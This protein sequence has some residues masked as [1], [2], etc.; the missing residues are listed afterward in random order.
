MLTPQEWEALDAIGIATLVKSG[1]V[2]GREMVETAI[3]RIE[4]LNPIVNAVVYR[5]FDDA[6]ELAGRKGRAGPRLG[7]SH[8]RLEDG[9]PVRMEASDTPCDAARPCVLVLPPA[10]E[11]SLPWRSMLLAM[12][13]EIANDEALTPVLHLAHALNV[14]VTI[15]HVVAAGAIRGARRH[16]ERSGTRQVRRG[17]SR[18]HEGAEALHRGLQY[19]NPLPPAQGQAY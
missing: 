18:H 8:W 16:L 7:V 12:S 3:N 19:A 5:A 6:M 10:Y 13:G 17:I 4:Q 14:G 9:R 2:S 15:A 11:A 1:E